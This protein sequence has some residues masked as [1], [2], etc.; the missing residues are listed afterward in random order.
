MKLLATTKRNLGSENAL[1]DR[2]NNVF[3]DS[4]IKEF[5]YAFKNS[6]SC[7]FHSSHSFLTF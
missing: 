3:N 1:I 5:N 7:T 4:S 2:L 6:F